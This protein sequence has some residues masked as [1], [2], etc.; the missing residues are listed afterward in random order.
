MFISQTLRLLGLFKNVNTRFPLK[1]GL[2]KPSMAITPSPPDYL[3]IHQ[4]AEIHT[5]TLTL[6]DVENNQLGT[7]LTP[8]SMEV[9]TLHYLS[10]AHILHVSIQ[11]VE[12]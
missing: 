10:S 3:Y 7:R 9:F 1:V 6:P 11:L 4:Q 5:M 8:L 12:V 2:D